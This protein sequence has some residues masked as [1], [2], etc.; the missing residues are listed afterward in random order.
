MALSYFNLFLTQEQTANALKPNPEDRNVSPSEM[1]AFVNE[2]TDLSALVRVN[3]N[4]ETLRR[5]VA[6]GFP[7]IVEL[8]LDPPGEYRWMGW[9]GHYLLIVAYDDASQEVWVY[10]SW[11]GTSEVPGENVNEDGRQLSYDELENYWRQFNST[12]IALYRP[13]EAAEVAEIIGPDM[14]DTAMWQ[15]ALT[16]AQAQAAAHPE[17]AYLWFNLG[18]IYSAHGEYQKAAI[19]YDQARATGLPWRMLWYQ[20]GPYEAYYQV[21]RYED[22]IMLADITLKD[23][24]YFEESYYFKGLALSALGDEEQARDNLAKAVRFNPNFTPA[25]EALDDLQA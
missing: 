22:V 5:L 11:F 8:G 9:Y 24:P 15:E 13:E 23:R 2:Q 10:D 1:A 6:G 12:Y 17:D 16:A 18:T 19:A 21:G 7:V 3:G 20:F 14:N 25:L 4:L